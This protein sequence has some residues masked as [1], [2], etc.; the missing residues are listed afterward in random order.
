MCYQ[1]DIAHVVRVISLNTVTECVIKPN[2]W[3]SNHMKS[4]LLLAKSQLLLLNLPVL[5]M[6]VGKN[7]VKYRQLLVES[8]CLA[9]NV[10][11]P[12]EKRD[13]GPTLEEF[14]GG[15]KVAPQV[16]S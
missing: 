13:P 9:S 10:L 1:Q 15:E 8:P 12:G 5:S 6:F 4:P 14:L 3:C 11:C 2:V 7:M 16:V